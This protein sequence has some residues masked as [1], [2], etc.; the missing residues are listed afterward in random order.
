MNFDYTAFQNKLASIPDVSD[1]E[2]ALLKDTASFYNTTNRAVTQGEPVLGS[3]ICFY[4]STE[5][6]PGCAIGR[7]LDRST[8]LSKA[9][10]LP[11][12]ATSVAVLLKSMPLEFPQWLRDMDEDFLTQLQH[13]HDGDSYWTATGLSDDGVAEFESMLEVCKRNREKRGNQI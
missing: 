10:H 6:T 2:V 12:G 5:T 4:Y 1:R 7:C 8:E 13:F 11:V 3:P 9:K